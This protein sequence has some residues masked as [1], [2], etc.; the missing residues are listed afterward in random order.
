MDL[1]FRT[2]NGVFNYRVCAIIKHNNK[3]LAMKNNNTP[4]Y[5]LPGGS[6]DLHETSENAILRELKEEL[7]IEAKIVRPLWFAQSFFIE[8]ESLEKF[9]ELCMYYLVDVSDTDLV[10]HERFEGLVTWNHEVFE[11][12]D[13]DTLNERY[14]YPLF[15]KG[16]INDLPERFEMLTEYEY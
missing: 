11:W 16:K 3:L 14:L 7:G 1:T 15:I 13:I 9:H 6:V 2:E 10:N 8:D 4:Y 12:L 5:F